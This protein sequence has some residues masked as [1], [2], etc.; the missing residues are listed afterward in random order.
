VT[1]KSELFPEPTV[2]DLLSDP[3]IRSVMRADAVD[4]AELRELLDR[5]SRRTQEAMVHHM[6]RRRVNCCNEP[7]SP[8][9]S[10][11]TQL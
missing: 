8:A 3:M 1:C 7:S 10:S 5:A 11:E 2:Q 9:A 6:P 4:E